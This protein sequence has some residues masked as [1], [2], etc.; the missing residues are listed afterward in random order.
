MIP[1]SV[2]TIGSY[3]FGSSNADFTLYASKGSYAQWYA[4]QN[5]IRFV[6]GFSYKELGNDNIEI[7]NYEGT[8]SDCVIPAFYNGKTVVGISD[9]AFYNNKYIEKVTISDTVKTIGKGAFDSCPKLRMIVIN[10]GVET[11]G[12]WAF[13]NCKSLESVVIPNTVYSLGASAFEKCYSLESV[14]LGT[15]I[16]KIEDDTFFD[17]RQLTTVNIP[18]TV[19]SIGEEAFTN[20]RNLS[21]ISIPNGVQTLGTKNSN[22]TM[23]LFENCK[24]LSKIIIPDSVTFIADNTFDGCDSLTVYGNSNSYAEEYAN[25]YRISFKSI[26]DITPSG[27]IGDSNLDGI[28]NIRDV[29]AIQRH[30]AE[31]ELFSD[32]HLVVADTNGD[33]EI[34]V[35]DATHL[36]MYLAEYNVILGKQP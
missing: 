19:T 30:I 13:Y 2:T 6:S 24:A 29:T 14:E 5:N 32:E 33:G 28:I 9:W 10:D 7:T 11:I 26:G 20:C 1:D 12:K 31:L 35:S 25:H 3:A 15:G 34:N 36:Q 22:N 4:Y 8:E 17:C 18:N 23:G 16:T 21:E 27:T